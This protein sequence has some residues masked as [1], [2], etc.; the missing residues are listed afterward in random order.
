ML[1]GL[2]SDAPYR[3]NQTGHIHDVMATGE[4]ASSTGGYKTD[5][6][7]EKYGGRTVDLLGF[8]NTELAGLMSKFT[9]FA[10]GKMSSDKPEDRESMEHMEHMEH[11]VHMLTGKRLDQEGLS[12]MFKAMGTDDKEAGAWAQRARNKKLQKML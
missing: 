2:E 11:M 12:N 6:V 5:L 7:G 10:G 4:E 1:V 8:N 3:M 9:D